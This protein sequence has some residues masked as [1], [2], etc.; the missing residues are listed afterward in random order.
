MCFLYISPNS[1]RRRRIEIDIHEFRKREFARAACDRDPWPRRPEGLKKTRAQPCNHEHNT[2]A[3]E[4]IHSADNRRNNIPM[5]SC[6]LLKHR[7]RKKNMERPEKLC[8]GGYTQQL[9]PALDPAVTSPC[10]DNSGSLPA[11]SS[12]LKSLTHLAVICASSQQK[13]KYSYSNGHFFLSLS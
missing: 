7:Q 1:R 11:R 5:P 12:S 6:Q 9:C 4:K 10:L 13:T 2:C 8:H 3:G